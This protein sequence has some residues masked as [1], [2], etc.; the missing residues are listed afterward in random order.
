MSEQRSTILI[1]RVWVDV[2]RLLTLEPESEVDYFCEFSGGNGYFLSED[3]A[4]FL[5]PENSSDA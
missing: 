5:F 1:G 4:P 2:R 3:L